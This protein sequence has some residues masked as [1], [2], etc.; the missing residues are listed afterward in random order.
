MAFKSIKYPNYKDALSEAVR[1]EK[2]TKNKAIMLDKV[3]LH[4]FS[5]IINQLENMFKVIQ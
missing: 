4:Y 1:T 2:N 3:N 5:E